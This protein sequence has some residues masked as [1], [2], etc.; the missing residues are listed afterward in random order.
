MVPYYPPDDASLAE[1]VRLRLSRIAQRLWDNHEI[2]CRFDEE[3]V[4]LM[5]NRCTEVESG[6]RMIKALLINGLL[7][8]ISQSVLCTTRAGLRYRESRVGVDGA[9][10]CCEV[11]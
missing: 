10:Y 11:T 8:Q 4:Q 5:V 3:L 1:I 2:A 6:A 9:G 7:P